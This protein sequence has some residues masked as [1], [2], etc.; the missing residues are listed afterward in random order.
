MDFI[1]LIPAIIW[2]FFKAILWILGIPIF[3][4]FVFH[5]LVEFHFEKGWI[6][7]KTRDKYTEAETILWWFLGGWWFYIFVVRDY[8]P[9]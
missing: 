9:F 3:L 4:Y 1:L 2:G 6:T 7:T 5:M 8:F